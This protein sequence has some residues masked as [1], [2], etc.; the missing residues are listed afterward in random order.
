MHALPS[1]ARARWRAL[2]ATLLIACATVAHAQDGVSANEIVIGQTA[3]FTGQVASQ[4]KEQTA[5]VRAYFAYVN[6]RGGVHG[7]K[8]VLKS[9]DD[10]Y[11]AKRAA[12]NAR[13]LIA[14]DRVF[15]LAF[16]RGTPTTEAVLPVLEEYKV[17]LIGPATGAQSLHEPV[18]RYVFNVRAKYRT[19]AMRI[20][21]HLARVQSTRIAVLYQNNSFGQDA[22][23]GYEQGLADQNL[24]P[25]VTVALDGAKPEKDVAGAVEKIV[26]V[27]P[28][29]VAIAGPLKP[30][31]E[32]IRALRAK[33]SF[34]QCSVL[35]NLSADAFIAELGDAAP[36][37]IVTQV[38]PFPWNAGI[39]LAKELQ[40][41][42]RAEPEPGATLSYASMEGFIYAKVLVE[43][44][45]R[46]GPNPTREKLIAALENMRSYDLGGFTV[47]FGPRRREGSTYIDITMIGKDRKFIR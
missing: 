2:V 3:G 39:P 33:G 16:S 38:V 44:L 46:A 31:A 19:E 26:A 30:T 7:R 21:E 8:L 1:S 40:Q 23:A 47:T 9:I 27:N 5:A 25:V 36:G 14:E 37:V 45:R 18:N 17:P 4:V 20:I 15:V 12:A 22:L 24:K 41:V 11:D 32:F 34:A 28:Q 10:G 43:A 29:A 6:Q 35:S 42:L 13:K